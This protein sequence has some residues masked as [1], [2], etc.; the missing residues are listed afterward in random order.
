MTY[1]AQSLSTH[2]TEAS[3]SDKWPCCGPLIVKDNVAAPHMALLFSGPIGLG[4]FLSVAVL[5]A[6]AS[7]VAVLSAAVLL[8]SAVS[9]AVLSAAALH[10]AVLSAAALLAAVLS[11]AALHAAVSSIVL[12]PAAVLLA[13]VLSYLTVLLSRHFCWVGDYVKNKTMCS[14]FLVLLSLPLY[15]TSLKH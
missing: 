5:P 12:L 8:A 3:S 7:S 13:V 2:C 14:S 4:V 9:A 15:G 11:A 10:A 1:R 6:A